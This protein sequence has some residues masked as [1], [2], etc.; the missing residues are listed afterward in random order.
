[1]FEAW[2]LREESFNV[3]VLEAWCKIAV[4]LGITCIYEKLNKMHIE[5]HDWDQYVLKKPRKRL[6]KERRD[7]KKVI[8]RSMNDENDS[9]KKELAELIEY[10]LEL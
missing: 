7:L 3:T 2:W 5:L 1:M 4:E 10:Q 6:R 9:K 8:S